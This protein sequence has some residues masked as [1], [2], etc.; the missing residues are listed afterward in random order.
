MIL[1]RMSAQ[2]HSR[3][4]GDRPTTS[5]LPQGTDL[6]RAGRHVSNGPEADLRSKIASLELSPSLGTYVAII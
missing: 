4:F 2:S 1:F 3:H 6:V 5:G